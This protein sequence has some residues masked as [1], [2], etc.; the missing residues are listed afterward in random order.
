MPRVSVI[1]PTYNCSLYLE[2]AVESA[3]RQ[4]YAD[5][6]I[7]ILDDGST[8][9]TNSLIPQWGEKVV[10]LRQANAGLSTARNNAIAGSSGEF[11]AYLDSDDMWYPE[12]LARQVEYLD[13]HPECGIVH[14]DMTIVD[15][16]DIVLFKDFHKETGKIPAQG[17]LD[18]LN[19]ASIQVPTVMERRSCFDA[20][21]GFD[22]RLRRVEDFLHWIQVALDGHAIGYLDETLAMYRW[23]RSSLSKN[24]PAMCEAMIQALRTLIDENSLR[25]RLGEPAERVAR[26]L[27]KSNRLTLPFHYR[28][29]GQ[30]KRAR[31]E[32]IRLILDDP[33]ELKAY[34]ELLKSCVPQNAARLAASTNRSGTDANASSKAHL[35]T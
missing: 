20:V 15:D 1:I 7:I 28:Q 33:L 26:A 9:D 11:L 4:T 8:D 30:N 21:G 17:A 16:D 35:G 12:K 19:Y 24:T 34:L 23:R 14:S 6:E 2:R 22:S 13:A 29:Q 25:Q 10:Y 32:S 27:I 3:L 18:I 5:R 31:Q